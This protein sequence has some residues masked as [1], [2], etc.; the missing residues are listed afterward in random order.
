MDAHTGAAKDHGAFELTLGNFCANL[1]A[2]AVEHFRMRVVGSGN[3]DVGNSPALC[4]QVL[5]D[6]LVEVVAGDVRGDAN[7]LI[8]DRLHNNSILPVSKLIYLHQ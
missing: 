2:D 1:E 6:S 3:A 5:D 4:L 7:L 8:L